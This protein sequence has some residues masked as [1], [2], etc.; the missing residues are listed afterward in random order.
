MHVSGDEDAD[1]IIKTARVGNV[2]DIKGRFQE[3]TRRKLKLTLPAASETTIAGMRTAGSPPLIGVRSPPPLAL[4]PSPCDLSPHQGCSDGNILQAETVQSQITS[5]CCSESER[6]EMRPNARRYW[7]PTDD[8]LVNVPPQ[9]GTRALY[10]AASPRREQQVIRVQ[11]YPGQQ[12]TKTRRDRGEGKGRMG[13]V[14]GLKPKSQSQGSH[15][16]AAPQGGEGAVFTPIRRQVM[17]Y[18][19]QPRQMPCPLCSCPPIGYSRLLQCRCA[20]PRAG[21]QGADIT[22][23]YRSHNLDT[24][25]HWV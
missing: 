3:M 21:V 18:V 1:D 10:Q 23:H 11:E 4:P 15:R 19:T 25:P 7:E 5:P 17:N 12:N 20:A 24:L 22:G 16:P 6:G 2:C 14:S 8:G 13:L 9:G